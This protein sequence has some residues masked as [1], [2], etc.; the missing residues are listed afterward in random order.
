VHKSIL[1]G[2]TLAIVLGT[3][4]T[5]IA[6]SGE[7]SV[8]IVHGLPG[9]TADIYVDGDLL[10]DGFKPTSI[11][12]PLRVPAGSHDVDIRE[13]GAP[14]TSSPALSGTVDVAPGSNISIVAHLT[15]GGDPVLS[16]F[17][18]AFER[19]PAGRSYLVVRYVAIGP[20]LSVTLD[21]H[22]VI[23]DL[24]SGGEQRVATSPGSSTIALLSRAGNDVVP[25]TDI[26]MEEGAA[27]IV[28]VT[29]SI[30]DRFGL[31]LML[32]SVGGTGSV[33]S[34]V[35]TGDGGLGAEPGF[36]NWGLALMIAAGITLFVC[37]LSIVKE[38]A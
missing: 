2:W 22:R 31:S 36:P 17:E 34:S 29:G 21:Q 25:S 6:I 9:F 11:A 35:L 24:T 7:G 8:T 4:T 37:T 30:T 18:N 33:P 28:Y 5:T 14:A 19:L 23:K 12:G 32:Q 27:Q 26:D 16:T 20:P 10:I 1:I 3:A 13:L 15:R 38:R